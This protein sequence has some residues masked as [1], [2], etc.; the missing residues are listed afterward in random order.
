MPSSP[1]D[2]A[3][4]ALFAP[5]AHSFRRRLSDMKERDNEAIV[6]AWRESIMDGLAVR[7]GLEAVRVRRGIPSLSR[8]QSS[9]M[10]P[11]GL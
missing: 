2:V 5:S 11:N 3:A 1:I 7:S 6:W 9:L 8:L 4:E 10:G